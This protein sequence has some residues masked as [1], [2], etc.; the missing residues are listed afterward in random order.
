M[1][2]GEQENEQAVAIGD[3]DGLTALIDRWSLDDCWTHVV[4]V[5]DRCRAALLRGKQLWPAAAYAE[6]RLALDAPAPFAAA[7]LGSSAER[8]T[9]GPFAEVMASTHRF[10]ALRDFLP[11]SPEAGMVAHECA[12]RG[13]Q[14]DQSDVPF[15]DVLGVPL[16]LA[17][18]E[19]EYELAEYQPAKAAF[20]SPLIPSVLELIS[21]P[22][23]RSSRAVEDPQTLRCLRDLVAAWVSGSNGRVD[24]MAVRGSAA[25]AVAT[26]GC[27]NHRRALIGPD[28]AM[29][30]M[31]WAAA[32][33]GAQGRRRGAAAGR[34]AAWWTLQHL[35]GFDSQDTVEPDELGQAASELRWFWWDDGSPS[36]GW[37]LRLAIEDPAEGLAWAIAA[38]D[39]KMA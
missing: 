32:S 36:T 33:G 10:S 1:S 12:L 16:Q 17:D 15:A 27:S 11:K 7:V 29:A 22:S 28:E 20:A 6:Y 26:L 31:A 2:S 18:W 38:S 39:A 37:A 30:H 19:P 35:A 9:L 5:R 13:E 23:K 25:D 21:V 14:F 8:F 3:L 4:D 24:V 34:A